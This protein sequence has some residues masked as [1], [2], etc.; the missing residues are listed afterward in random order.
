MASR[1]RDAWY[2]RTTQQGVFMKVATLPAI[3][4]NGPVQSLT[5]AKKPK[6]SSE[7]YF[8]VGKTPIGGDEV[9]GGI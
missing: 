4:R 5:D 6:P 2:S 3:I 7:K 8:V 1:V 9:V